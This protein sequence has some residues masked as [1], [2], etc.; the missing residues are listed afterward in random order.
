MYAGQG[1]QAKARRLPMIGQS[2]RWRELPA[3]RWIVASALAVAA[4]AV[5]FM[6]PD[7][8]VV[9]RPSLL[10]LVLAI[11]VGLLAFL[12]LESRVLQRDLR[13]ARVR[14]VD[15]RDMERQRIQRDLH[16]SAQQ[17]LVSVR[18]HLGLLADVA[19]DPAERARIEQLGMDLDT[20][21]AEIAAVTR[22]GYPQ[23]LQLRGVAPS[24]RSAALHSPV[25]VTIEADG[26]GRYPEPVER[27]VYFCCVEALQNVVKHAGRNAKARVRLSG[28]PTRVVFEVEDS[29]VG[30]DPV[31][32][33][34]GDG[35]VNLAD[36]VGTMHGR[37]TVDS[38]PGMGTR[39]RGE[40][41]LQ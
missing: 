17:R 36:R 16:D 23:L 39:I 26:F 19:E 25:P 32:V 37:L 11:S 8:V 13:G 5:F 29:G 22:D 6:A 20:A 27:N 9:G 14:A 34:P 4:V 12:Q 18:I 33:K 38:R 30:F 21:L 10:A 41:P 31:R 24:L 3:A 40:I 28:T 15:S 7:W 2:I 1:P 35:L